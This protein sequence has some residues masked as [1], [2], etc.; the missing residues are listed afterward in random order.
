M[1]P[2]SAPRTPPETTPG[3]GRERREAP[4]LHPRCVRPHGWWVPVRL[5][6]PFWLPVRDGQD[7][8]HSPGAPRRGEVSDSMASTPPR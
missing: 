1:S 7:E 2:G 3:R 5:P 4:R 8:N 6:G